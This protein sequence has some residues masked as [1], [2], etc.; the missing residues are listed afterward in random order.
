MSDTITIAV[1]NIDEEPKII[2]IPADTEGSLAA[3][4]K[5]VG[6]YIETFPFEG[7]LAVCNEEGLLKKLDLNFIYDGQYIVGNVAF[8]AQKGESFGSLNPQQ[9]DL[10]MHRLSLKHRLKL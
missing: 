5:I 8:A 9:I 4:Q 6:G 3:L 2:D 7:F 1:K 10:I